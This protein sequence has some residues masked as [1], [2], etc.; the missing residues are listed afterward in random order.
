VDPVGLSIAIV[1]GVAGYIVVHRHQR[2]ST[3][4]GIARNHLQS[5]GVDLTKPQRLN[6]YFFAPDR[7]SLESIVPSLSAKGFS[8]EIFAAD[9]TEAFTLCATRE[10][11][12]RI[13]ILLDFETR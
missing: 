2:M 13:G 12:P 1:V 10:L 7:S 9:S 6:F 4:D 3:A 5:A 8:T 11:V